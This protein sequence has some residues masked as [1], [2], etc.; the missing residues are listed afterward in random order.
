M[1]RR[2]SKIIA[3]FLLLIFSEQAGLRLW[4]HHWFH[5]YKTSVRHATP[6]AE[7]IH[8]VCDCYQEAMMPLEGAAFF[9]LCIPL[10]KATE[11][12]DAPQIRVPDAWKLYCSLKGPPAPPSH[13]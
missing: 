5:E 3:F 12:I 2:H 1:L 8:P 4:M 13:S 6:A 11:L 9:T 7:T 10:Q